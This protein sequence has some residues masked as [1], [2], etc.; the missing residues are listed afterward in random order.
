MEKKT[1][2][3]DWL[4]P[5]RM[6][7]ILG[8]LAGLAGV[9][10]SALRPQPAP[11]PRILILPRSYAPPPSHIPLFARL[12]PTTKSFAWLWHLK[13]AVCGKVRPIGIDVQI[14]TLPSLA[15]TYLPQPT[16]ETTASSD[17]PDL[18]VW[19]MPQEDLAVLRQRLKQTSEVEFVNSARLLTGDRIDASLYVGDTIVLNGATNDVG[20]R[21]T[22]LPRL[23][24]DVA[25]LTVLVWYVRASTNLAP[26]DLLQ[27]PSNSIALQTNLE[28]KARFQLPKGKSIFV[29][30][31]PP[32]PS[33]GNM[34]GVMLSTK[35]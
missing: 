30:Q 26:S 24:G 9:L 7:L 29:L 13:E 2:R 31:S 11:P 1:S 23:H 22:C 33:L 10:A 12:V 28:V 19:V 34:T 27:A 16:V 35:H 18:K 20:L 17:S 25:D 14:I 5:G 32:D 21:L 8:V 15:R 6:L 4:R 3:S